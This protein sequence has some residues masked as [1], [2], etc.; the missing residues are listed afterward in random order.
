MT[1]DMRAKPFDLKQVRLLDGPF[2][3]AM[4]RDQEYLLQLEPADY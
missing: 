1:I 4:Q 3:D 2:K